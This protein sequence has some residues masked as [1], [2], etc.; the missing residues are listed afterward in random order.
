MV[1]GDL[2]RAGPTAEDP[3]DDAVENDGI[4]PSISSIVDEVSSRLGHDPDFDQVVV[5]G[6]G[7]PTLRMD[8]LLAVAKRVG[9]G[10]RRLPV[11]VLTN[12]LCYGIENLGYSPRN[13]DRSGVV[14][15]MLRHVILRDMME[16]GVSRLSVALHTENRHKYDILMEPCCH[17]GGELSV[18]CWATES[19]DEQRMAGDPR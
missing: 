17:T 13:A 4:E 1:A 14:M 16:A 18:G 9:D 12:G 15:P 2:A 3:E 5:A 11:R 8:A 10:E 19:I 6:E 7:E